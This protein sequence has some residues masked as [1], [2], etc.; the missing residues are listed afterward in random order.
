MPYFSIIKCLSEERKERKGG[1]RVINF[2]LI[3]LSFLFHVCV[4]FSGL[5]VFLHFRV[6]S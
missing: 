2:F 1:L 6:L 5:F 4:L 3:R